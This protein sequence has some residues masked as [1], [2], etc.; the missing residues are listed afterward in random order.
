MILAAVV[1]RSGA[2]RPMV[3]GCLALAAAGVG[4][5]RLWSFQSTTLARVKEIQ[6]VT[7]QLPHLEREK[8]Y[9]SSHQCRACHPAEHASWHRTYHR[10]M[11]QLA[12]PE[13][14]VAD[15]DGSTTVSHGLPYRVYRE[16]D[17][18]WAEMPD[19]DEMM[20]I[21]LG[22]KKTRL[23]DVPRVRRQVVMTTGSHH[24]QTYWVCSPRYERLMQTLPLVYLIKDHR[25]IPREA[26]FMHPPG[27]YPMITQ[28]NHHCIRCHS[29][30][31]VP[32]LDQKT[33][34]LHT[35][36]G[37]LGIACEACHGPGEEHVR[38]NQD[39][40]RRY[41]LQLTGRPDPTIVNPAR[42]G[43]RKSSQ[44]CGQCHGVFIDREDYALKYAEQGSLYTPG[45]NLYKTRYYIQHPQKETTTERLVDLEKN[46]QFF[47]E[48]WWEDGTVLAGGREFTAMS[49]SACYT[50]GNI[51]CLS[52][53][54]MHQSDP[55]DQLKP[56][57]DTS[58][59]CIQ[60]H[61]EPKYSSQIATHT[62]HRPTSEGSNCLNCHMPYATYAL[63]GGIRSHQIES[64]QVSSSIRHG[65]PNACN[66][67][68]LDK[69][70]AW[71]QDHLAKWYEYEKLP[72]SEEQ[73]FVSAAL[74]WL[75]KGHAAQRAIAA[76]HV[77]WKPAQEA[78]G[79]D[80]LAP[81]QAQLLADP[82]GVVRY[83]ALHGLQTLPGFANFG[84]NFLEDQDAL[85]GAV[86]QA[87]E[88][89]EKGL[90]GPPSRTGE[91]VLIRADGSLDEQK[92]EGLMEQRD[93]RPVTI[94]E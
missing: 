19:P 62:H 72:L 48:R 56:A 74:L 94:K 55:V 39:P 36:V 81:H 9:V 6:L 20:Y 85:R 79:S 8:D 26:A 88:R 18:F 57:M 15:F 52:C 5:L 86:R 46:P 30:G 4:G 38:A 64:P 47:Q 73:Q 41:E 78:S 24:Y 54:S 49:V 35:S 22:G 58:A 80:W 29:T 32:G 11:T 70:L 27:A 14:V 66:L 59:A 63:L 50:R 23:E 51:S 2:R 37:E 75:L 82:Y 44:I 17:Q 69:T 3:L 13:N 7:S 1:W 45:E 25:W 68:H 33:G 34:R 71:S 92:L 93:N 12:L 67:C 83:V 77:G 90:R 42:L 10:T 60:C 21:V 76:W 16:G 89:W 61:R 53:H 43:H 91:N 87:V 31:G 28:W 65:V 40:L 84:Y